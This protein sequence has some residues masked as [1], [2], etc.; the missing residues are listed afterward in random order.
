MWVETRTTRMVRR[1][2]PLGMMK[3]VV[4]EDMTIGV[5]EWVISVPAC[6]FRRS[7]EV[8]F[9][10]LILVGRRMVVSTSM[11]MPIVMMLV[12]AHILL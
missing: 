11:S 12:Y 10:H 6:T 2:I 9:F 5:S 1:E 4:F 7:P 3:V 8:D